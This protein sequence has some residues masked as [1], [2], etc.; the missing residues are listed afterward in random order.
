MSMYE[1]AL[2][3]ALH[4]I[5]PNTVP[6]I[7]GNT[8][9]PEPI[10]TYLA[11]R[12]IHMNPTGMARQSTYA[13]GAYGQEK[14]NLAETYEWFVQI[15]V[16]GP[17]ADNIVMSLMTMLKSSPGQISFE[18]RG[19]SIMRWTQV[20]RV[21]L[22]REDNWVEA[23]NFEVYLMFEQQTNIA[24]PVIDYINFTDQS[25]VPNQNVWV[26]NAPPTP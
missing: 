12:P 21:P 19:L 5:V 1:D 9:I 22:K 8:D 25:I 15:N 26:P 10:V 6:I 13:T 16:V 20:R 3:D 2:Y 23:R 18:S 24:S 4:D 7:Y 17:N 11:I 14:T